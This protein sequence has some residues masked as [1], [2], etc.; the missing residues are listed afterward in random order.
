MKNFECTFRLN[1]RVM[2]EIVTLKF[3]TTQDARKITEGKY[4]GQD[5][6]FIAVR[7]L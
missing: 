3:G 2:K 5:F 1:G 6:H 7:I 4:S